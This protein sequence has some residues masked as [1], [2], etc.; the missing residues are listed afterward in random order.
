MFLLD[1]LAN[2]PKSFEAAQRFVE[3]ILQNTVKLLV[4]LREMWRIGACWER[5]FSSQL[6][7]LI[8]KKTTTMKTTH[9]S[10]IVGWFQWD[11]L[12]STHSGKQDALPGQGP[13]PHST[14]LGTVQ[15]NLFFPENTFYSWD[16]R[17]PVVISGKTTAKLLLLIPDYRPWTTKN[18]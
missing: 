18:S 7:W 11:D 13:R 5:N 8:R 15:Q 4:L 12:K 2:S 17:C 9:F 6:M 16:A 14:I 10:V 1:K 3:W